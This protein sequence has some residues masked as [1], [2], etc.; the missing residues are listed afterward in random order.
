MLAR[1]ASIMFATAHASHASG[2]PAH[3]LSELLGVNSGVTRVAAS[4]EVTARGKS[5]GSLELF[6]HVTFL[7]EPALN[8]PVTERRYVVYLN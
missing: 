4:T 1:C 7:S 5:I 3:C 8:T 2:H 6:T